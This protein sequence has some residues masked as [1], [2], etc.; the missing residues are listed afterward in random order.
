MRDLADEINR[1]I[2]RKLKD[3]QKMLGEYD[4]KEKDEI[5]QEIEQEIEYEGNIHSWEIYGS[6]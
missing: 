4:D 1:S 5:E 3:F 2:G 6:E